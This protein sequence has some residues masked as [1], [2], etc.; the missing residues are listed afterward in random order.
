MQKFHH[1]PEFNNSSALKC[2][3]NGHCDCTSLQFKT[4]N[5]HHWTAFATKTTWIRECVW[6]LVGAYGKWWWVMDSRGRIH[7]SQSAPCGSSHFS[8][9]C[10]MFVSNRQRRRL[11][12]AVGKQSRVP[13]AG[14]VMGT[15]MSC[16][17]PGNRCPR[18]LRWQAGPSWPPTKMHRATSIM[19]FD[20]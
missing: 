2:L 19:K 8:H 13:P 4:S 10:R 18:G 7:A 3:D 5:I 15:C 12:T 17:L 1:W 6:M 9:W 16:G 11:R 20:F 14:C